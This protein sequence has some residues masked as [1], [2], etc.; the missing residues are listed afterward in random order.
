MSAHAVTDHVYP[1]QYSRRYTSFASQL[2]LHEDTD[3][4][5]AA[6]VVTGS[7]TD[8]IAHLPCQ[9]VVEAAAADV[10]AYLDGGGQ[11]VSLTFDVAGVYTFRMAPS[12]IET[13]TTVDAVTVFWNQ[14][15]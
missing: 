4:G 15:G 14:R 5:G 8:R 6:P 9:V 7:G 3:H 13:T 1:P 10:F 11:L 12:S 2:V